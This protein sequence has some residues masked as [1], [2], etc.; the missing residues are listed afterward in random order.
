[1]SLHPMENN[2]F[3]VQFY[4]WLIWLYPV[5]FRQAY[6]QDMVFVFQDLCS[7]TFAQSGRI[8]LFFLWL[9]TL[10]DLLRSVLKEHIADQ[11]SLETTLTFVSILFAIPT[12]SFWLI[13]YYFLSDT[14]FQ[15]QVVNSSGFNLT[16]LIFPLVVGILQPIG[17]ATSIY[18]VK[19]NINRPINALMT[20]T[21]LLGYI[22]IFYAAL[23]NS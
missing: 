10:P 7:Q 8:G 4:R 6:G 13:G 19:N 14:G 11:E 1:M 23:S 3:S 9:R 16:I 20:F 17:L 15:Q 21:H 22:A 5:K 12:T 18:N 2:I